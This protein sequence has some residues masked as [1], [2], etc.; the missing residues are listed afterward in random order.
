M[1]VDT[2]CDMFGYLDPAA[3]QLPWNF[4]VTLRVDANVDD[5]KIYYLA[6]HP[7]DR[8]ASFTGSGLP[9]PTIDIALRDSPNKGTAEADAIGNYVINMMY[10]NTYYHGKQVV[11]PTLHVFY[12]VNGTGTVQGVPLGPRIPARDVVTQVTSP[13]YY[14]DQFN[15]PVQSSERIFAAKGYVI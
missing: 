3:E 1:N 11:P 4:A 12:Y 10:P 2:F 7:A 8:M 14:A 13:D 15:R 9:S 5:G 6:A